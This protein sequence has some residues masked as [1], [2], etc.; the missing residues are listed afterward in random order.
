MTTWYHFGVEGE[1]KKH[2]ES[3]KKRMDNFKLKELNKEYKYALLVGS[4]LHLMSI[5]EQIF[6]LCHKDND[7]RE[8]FLRSTLPINKALQVYFPDSNIRGDVILIKIYR[9][10]NGDSDDTLLL[11]DWSLEELRDYEEFMHEPFMGMGGAMSEGGYI[12]DFTRRWEI[13]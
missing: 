12:V 5:S 4:P 9:D 10:E 1:I 7:G 2:A 8:N 6:I 3:K 13:E 11:E